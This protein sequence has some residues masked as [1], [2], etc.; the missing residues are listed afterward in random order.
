VGFNENKRLSKKDGKKQM[1]YEKSWPVRFQFNGQGE[2]YLLRMLKCTVGV[3][4]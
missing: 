2:K 1:T 4:F 3:K